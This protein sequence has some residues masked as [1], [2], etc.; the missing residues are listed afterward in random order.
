MADAARKELET[1]SLI[2]RVESVYVTGACGD[3]AYS[4]E[5]LV[6]PGKIVKVTFSSSSFSVGSTL[7]D[8]AQYALADVLCREP[9]RKDSSFDEYECGICTSLYFN[10]RLSDT[11]CQSCNRCYHSICLLD[12]FESSPATAKIAFGHFTGPC[13]F[14]DNELRLP[15]K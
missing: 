9:L 14:C 15:L 1:C 2:E 8:S 4:R 6:G 11:A 3:D 10:A 12:W 5:L 13:C 7:Y